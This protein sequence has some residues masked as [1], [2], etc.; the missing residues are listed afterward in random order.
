[1][2]TILADRYRLVRSLGEGGMG[3]VWEAHDQALKRTVAVKLI[4][5]LAGGGS[6]AGELRARF[7][8]EARITA[9][10]QHPNVVTLH[11]LGEATTP[12]GTMPFLVME[13]VRGRGLDTILREGPVAPA[14]AA[15]WGLQICDALGEAHRAGIVHRDI[16]PAN[17]IVTHSGTVKVLDFGIARAADPSLAPGR[18]TTRTVSI[19]G[20]PR[21]MA[22]EQAQSRP[23][24][25][26]DLY[27]L[28]C[29]LYEMVTG[30]PPFSAYDALGYVTAHLL[31]APAA[32]S[33]VAPG[34]PPAWDD[35]LLTLLQK[36]PEARYA[37]AAD[38][39]TRLR[40]LADTT[41]HPPTV[42]DR[43]VPFGGAAAEDVQDI[44]PPER[45]SPRLLRTITA[46]SDARVS[47]VRF[48]TDGSRLA[49][50]QSNGPTLVTDLAGQP[51]LSIGEPSLCL[52]VGPDGQ[53]LATGGGKVVR[54]WDISGGGEMR[55]FVHR[56]Y[57]LSLGIS[58][59]WRYLATAAGRALHLWDAA[60]GQKMHQIDHRKYA[61][62]IA[63][64]PDSTRV[65]TAGPGAGGPWVWDARTGELLSDGHGQDTAAVAFSPDGRTLATAKRLRGRQWSVSVPDVAGGK[66]FLSFTTAPIPR[67]QGH[68]V[69]LQ[70]SPDGRQL[71][72]EVGAN[73]YVHDTLTGTELFSIIHDSVL[74]AVCTSHGDRLA[75]SHNK[76]VRLLDSL[77][78][79]KLLE[80]THPE[81]VVS[82]EFSPD[83][84]LL[85]ATGFTGTLQLWSLT[86]S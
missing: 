17:L 24:Q 6:H 30:R 73:V 14:D 37:T 4:S 51:L 52:A 12:D 21:Y 69:R 20:T 54:F 49:V 25:R 56:K 18:L 72:T 26:S 16:K 38:L 29:V 81:P 7:L 85:A 10:L 86:E 35:V 83:G 75:T 9:A 31:D 33:S 28:G 61:S 23:E 19:L 46:G 8:R 32:P 48:S 63:W 27:A 59:D 80:F 68:Y 57:V 62:S 3:Q 42:V 84:S 67:S 22:P 41:G 15:R 71:L 50:A 74:V 5:V 60:T 36:N 55:R 45:F 79:A 64:S 70:F 47:D 13:L 82:L 11:D 78:G 65:A 43:G 34:I 77:T 53:C 44:R 2:D 1:M 40:P 66:E 58:P 76:T 39:A